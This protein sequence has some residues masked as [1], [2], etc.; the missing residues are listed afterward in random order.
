MA[1]LPA[2]NI[3]LVRMSALGDTVHALALM[4]G[5]RHGYPNAHLTWILQ[6]LPYEM[7]KQQPGIDEFIVFNPRQGV[8]AWYRLAKA[9]RKRRFDLTII[10]Q[11]SAKASIIA[12]LIKAKVK[13]G[14]DVGRSRELHWLVT[15]HK[16]PPRPPQHVQDQFFEF[17]DYVGITDYPIEWNFTFTDEEIAWRSAFFE[18]IDR[19]VI[20]FVTASS[21]PEKDWPYSGYAAVMD[22]VAHTHHLQPLIVG[23]PSER[24]WTVARK[25]FEA[26]RC[27]PVIGLERPIRRT[28]LQLSGSVMVVSPDT[29]PLHAA[30]ALGIPTVSLYG[31]SNP[32][33]CGPYRRFH[34]LLIDKY[35]SEEDDAHHVHRKTR[36]NRMVQ[37]SPDEVIEKIELGLAKYVRP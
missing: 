9:L 16:L 28:L 13:L 26:C 25:I 11:V 36:P 32:R 15:N 6:E 14:Y 29:G 22:Y 3:C 23:G 34:D 1:L 37:I 20:A 7:V 17:L 12:A 27:K 31:Y 5:L 19:P 24:E 4:N 33:R 10:P 35:T 18:P 2:H 21:K 30:V 8:N